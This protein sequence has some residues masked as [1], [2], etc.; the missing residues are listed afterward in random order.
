MRTPARVA[1][2]PIHPMLVAFPIGLWV[3]SFVCDLIFLAARTPAWNTAAYF[4]LCGGIV[5]AVSAAVPGL[6]DGL[7]LRKS[8]IF[9]TV[10][11]HMALNLLALMMFVMSFLSR[12]IEAP[13]SW[14][15]TLSA[16]GL[17]SLA[18]GGWF[19]GELVFVHGLGVEPPAEHRH[20]V[21]AQSEPP[22]RSLRRT[23]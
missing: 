8:P 3:F 12:S 1:G 18:I 15:L 4:A 20:P 2:H 13:F 7:F 17:V 9:R 19:G 6:V 22:P 5:G 14:S 23:S 21:Q 10:L 11:T 16:I